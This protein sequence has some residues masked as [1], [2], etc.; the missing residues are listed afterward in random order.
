[1]RGDGDPA[2]ADHDDDEEKREVAEAELAAEVRL[3]LV[4]HAIGGGALE[5]IV[6]FSY[7]AE[8][9]RRCW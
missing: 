5:F 3:R 9:W 8:D 6:P 7:A 4:R 1:M 2:R